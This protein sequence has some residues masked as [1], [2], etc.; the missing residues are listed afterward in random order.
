[1]TQINAILNSLENQTENFFYE[2]FGSNREVNHLNEEEFK[3]MYGNWFCGE[4]FKLFVQAAIVFQNVF[5]TDEP[6]IE[7]KMKIAGDILNYKIECF[8]EILKDKIFIG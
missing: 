7:C 2:L 5:P 8:E 4:A 1:M 6:N 3:K